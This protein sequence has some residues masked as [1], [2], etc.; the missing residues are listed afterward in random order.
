MTR[1]RFNENPI[2]ELLTFSDY[3]GIYYEEP[4]ILHYTAK[5][6][7]FTHWVDH[8]NHF[9]YSVSKESPNN[10]CEDNFELLKNEIEIGLINCNF[11]SQ[12]DEVKQCEN[13]IELNHCIIKQYTDETN[14]YNFVNSELRSCHHLQ[15][16]PEPSDDFIQKHSS[17]LSAW[18]LQLNT[19][20]RFEE[21]FT[22]T[23]YRG[24]TLSSDEI[25][26]YKENI[27][28]IV[29]WSPF[30]SASKNMNECLDGNVLFKI[31]TESA[32]SE[33]NKRYPRSIAHLSFFPY[34]EE[35]IYPIACAYR[36]KSVENSSNITTISLSTVDHN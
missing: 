22:N 24:A 32:I 23:A 33:Y 10:T 18:I 30:I 26:M 2:D 20:I 27:D 6:L 3:L 21:E 17:K 31:R 1:L 9:W 5:K 4:L 13:E 19:A 12:A 28:E 34:E 7:A 29:I 25:K 35:V 11:S 8:L 16:E 14:L 15:K 36:I